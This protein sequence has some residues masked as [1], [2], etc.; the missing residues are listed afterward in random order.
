[1]RGGTRSVRAIALVLTLLSASLFSLVLVP[2]E[3]SGYTPHA[4][5]TINGN[6]EFTGANGVTGG[7]GTAM[8]PYI[9]EG[10]EINASSKTGIEIRNTDAFFAVRNVFVHSGLNGSLMTHD[11]IYLYNVLNG[12][13][14]NSTF[15]YNENGMHL[16][17]ANLTVLFGNHVAYNSENGIFSGFSYDGIIAG[18]TLNANL[19]NG[20]LISGSDY[21]LITNNKVF[22]QE[23]GIEISVSEEV[24]VSLNEIWN[25]TEGMLITGSFKPTIDSNHVHDNQE[26]I[27]LSSS[28]YATIVDNT[29]SFNNRTGLYFFTSFNPIITG[30]LVE[31]NGFFG[32]YLYAMTDAMLES[33]EVYTN[34]FCGVL[35]KFSL[36]TT[37]RTSNVSLN[38]DYGLCVESSENNTV[39]NNEILMN[40][41]D[42]MIISDSYNGSLDYNDIISNGGNGI[43]FNTSYSMRL[44][45]NEISDNGWSGILS[46]FSSELDIFENRISNND[47]GATLVSSDLNLFHN[48]AIRLSAYVGISLTS[49]VSNRL[50]HN[51]IIANTQQA[52][53]NTASNQWDDGYPS[54]GNY[55]SDYTGP[56]Q[57]N[58]PNQDIPGFDFI[59]DTPYVI[60]ADSEDRYPFTI[61]VSGDS[62]PPIVN[63]TF[64]LD[65]QIFNTE[66]ITVTGTAQDSGGS[67]LE[68][69]MFRNP[70]L[71]LGWTPANGTSSWNAVVNLLPG[72]NTIEARAWD[73]D[74]NPSLIDLVTITYDPPGNDPPEAN[75]TVKPASGVLSKKFTVNASTSVDLED[76]TSALAVRW[77]WED[78]GTWDTLWSTTK[79]G[80]HQ[81][82]SPGTYNI[83]LQV[84]D[85]GGLTNETTRQV[86][87]TAPPPPPVN[88]RPNCDIVAPGQGDTLTGAYTIRGTAS[89]SDGSLSKVEIKIDNGEWIMVNGKKSWS[90]ELDTTTVSNGEHTIHARSF[91]GEDYSSTD[92]VAIT[93][94]NAQ[95]QEGDLDVLWFSVAIILLILTIVLLGLLFL[96]MRKRK[97]EEETVEESE[98]SLPEE[99]VGAED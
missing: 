50:Y 25:N 58:G 26:G 18:N 13:I 7:S 71:I 40:A 63:I 79:T 49:S 98:T 6:A 89:D 93:V 88:Q 51:N 30:N 72:L 96:A 38:N 75:F 42:G 22:D 52:Y 11:G 82:A 66:P 69:V 19:Q 84:M 91:D 20:I 70:P 24:E 28:N 55:W 39:F 33:N 90:L 67:G 77:D 46:R 78:D 21:C 15:L 10:W 68:T 12:K 53:D 35:V 1:M 41:D 17:Y 85:T 34:N 16:F 4:P 32:I 59:G 73:Y 3:T 31:G 56:D 81:Y 99:E 27:L 8:D 45:W 97:A 43:F 37:I 60:D 65:G 23:H 94:E 57:M 54:G 2:E 95:V 9:V 29:I 83:R 36:F 61:P 62:I 48:N 47:Y 5:I 44:S 80:Q 92:S 86:T 14:E 74:W 76:P 64:P 87:V